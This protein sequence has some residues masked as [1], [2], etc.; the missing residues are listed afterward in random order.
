LVL[1]DSGWAQILLLVRTLLQ[2]KQDMKKPNAHVCYLLSIPADF[3][4]PHTCCGKAI[5]HRSY[6]FS[7]TECLHFSVRKV[8][9]QRCR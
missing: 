3:Y 5:A 1:V 9:L 4:R 6:S 2:E 8:S 7:A